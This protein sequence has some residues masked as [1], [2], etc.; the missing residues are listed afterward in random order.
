MLINGGQSTE[1]YQALD[2]NISHWLFVDADISWSPGAID[3]LLAHDK[4]IISASYIA[5]EGA[6][7]V[8]EAGMYEV[9]EGNIGGRVS[10]EST[11]LNKVDWVGAG[12]LLCKRR[13]L[14]RMQ[15]PWFSHPIIRHTEQAEGREIYHQVMT[16][17]DV[18]FSMNARAS[19]LDIWIDCDTQVFHQLEWEPP[20]QVTRPVTHAEVGGGP[21]LN[22][23]I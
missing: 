14:E 17:E 22:Q 1:V 4:D 9:V 6:G 16:N 23:R 19:G 7:K 12:F 5:R 13:A 18:G 21:T 10:R 20:I 8:Y 15:H 11:G 3:R 2:T